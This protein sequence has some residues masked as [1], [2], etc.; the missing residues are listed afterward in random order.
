MVTDQQVVLLRQKLMEGKRQETSA[1]MA[2]F[3]RSSAN[4]LLSI[5]LWDISAPLYLSNLTHPREL[6]QT[7]LYSLFLL[8]NLSHHC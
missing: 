3:V 7:S 4:S 1:A 6:S 5:L 8:P 2:S